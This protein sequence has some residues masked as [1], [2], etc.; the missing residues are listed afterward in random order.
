MMSNKAHH[1]QDLINIFNECFALTH[2]TRLVKGGDEPLY[3]PANENQPYHAIYFARG[4]FSSALH[5]CAHWFIAGEKRR[6]QEDYGYWYVPDGRNAKQQEHF[7]LVEAKPQAIEWILSIAA[8]Y[9]FVLSIDNLNGEEFNSIE[10]KN[11]IYKQVI[12]FYQK[13]LPPRAELFRKRLSCFYETDED[14]S[15]LLTEP[16]PLGLGSVRSPINK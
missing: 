15:K 3:L 10:F 6:L 8:G 14:V 4:F 1:Y 9:R 7:Q 5:E 12:N 16:R 2:N 13:G 11:R